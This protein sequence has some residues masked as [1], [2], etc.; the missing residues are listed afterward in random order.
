[1]YIALLLTN[2]SKPWGD[3]SSEVGL[4]VS[5]D[6]GRTFTG[7]MI[8]PPKAKTPNWLPS[9]ERHTGHNRIDVPWLIYTHGPSKEKDRL[10]KKN[11][12][13]R[14][15]ALS[16]GRIPPDARTVRVAGIVLKWTPKDRETSFRRV[17]GLIR[18]AVAGGAKI[19]CTTESF[20]DGYSIRDKKMPLADYRALA[21]PI[22]G[23][24]YLKRLRALAEELKIHL[25]AGLLRR[26]GDKT[27]N[28][29]VVI[30]PDGRL[31]GTYHKQHLGHE[32]VRNT[33][34]N[35]CPTFQ[36]PYGRVG[37]MICADRRYPEV[38][39]GLVKNKADFILVPSGGMWGPI[40]NDKHLRARSAQSNLPI[41]FVHPIEFLVT[42]P[43]GIIWDRDF[44]GHQMDAG[45]GEIDTPADQKGVF[46][47]DL[48]IPRQPT[49]RHP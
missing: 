7:Q 44:R 33:P 48:P 11:F 24:A 29:A 47:F 30:G 36:T 19:V 12:E 15:V 6:N 40:S 9:L 16:A 14:L 37:V 18:E 35:Q 38:T 4:L 21:E 17:E 23:G 25:V 22:P 10:A 39:A 32:R 46:L 13:P 42:G 27:H 2:K 5:D 28:A 45:P 31:L 3:P 43:G 34:G 26:D 1:L 41:V 20:L 49:R 8:S